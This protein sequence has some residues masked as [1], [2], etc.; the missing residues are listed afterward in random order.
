M[1]NAFTEY[2][3]EYEVFKMSPRIGGGYGG[4]TDKRTVSGYLSWRKGGKGNI[5]DDT[6]VPNQKGTFW[7]RCGADAAGTQIKQFDYIE[8]GGYILQFVEDD[9]FTMEG[10]FIRWALQAAPVLD[11]R[12]HTNH[13]VDDV[14]RND[15]A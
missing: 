14:I 7:E 3:R 5:E 4:R 11:G 2:I 15:Y 9:D 10:G 1:L 13:V 8:A 6:K 12:Q